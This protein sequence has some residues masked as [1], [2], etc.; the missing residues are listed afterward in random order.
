MI[1]NRLITSSL[2]LLASVILVSCDSD[3][4]KMAKKMNDDR[5]SSFLKKQE[6]E[7]IHTSDSVR[8]SVAEYARTMPKFYDKEI[9]ITRIDTISVKGNVWCKLY[10]KNESQMDSISFASKV[11][12]ILNNIQPYKDWIKY[13]RYSLN[14]ELWCYE[15]TQTGDTIRFATVPPRNY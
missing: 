1:L 4:K 12:S 7:R 3:I 13:G 15:I 2:I 11:D 6:S 9:C 5:M 14:V 8:I 10:I